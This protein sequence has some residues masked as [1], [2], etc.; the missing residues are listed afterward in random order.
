M[1]VVSAGLVLL[2]TVGCAKGSAESAIA[3][4][5]KAVND[6][7]AEAAKLA[8]TELKALT[9][10]I[11]AMKAHIAAGEYRAALMGSRSAATLARDLG[12]GLA[13][14]KEQLTTSFNA[15]AGELPDQL[16]AV[17]AKVTELGA[18]RRLPA[19]IDATKFATLKSEVGSWDAAWKAATE[20]FAAGNLSDALNQARSIAAKVADA[21]TLLGLK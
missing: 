6:I 2:G 16:S 14:R 13:K 19:G 15:V 12:S 10:S 17:S 1:R 5:E 9:D 7:S 8:P 3:S 11:A 4:A 21:K 20:A 18:M